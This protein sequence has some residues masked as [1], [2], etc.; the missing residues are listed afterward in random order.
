[1]SE[2]GRRNVRGQRP[3]GASV[4]VTYLARAHLPQAQAYLD[5]EQFEQS[6]FSSVPQTIVNQPPEPWMAALTLPDL[7][8]RWNARLVEYLRYFR[9]NPRGQNLIRG[10]I[11]R[12]GRYEHILAPILR[13]VGV[14]EDLMF[15]AMA[16]SGFNPT[17]RSRVGATG[18]WQFMSGT[19]QVYGL[20]QNYWIDERKDIERA[21]YA[22]AAYLKDLRVR[23]GSWEM[24]LAA[25]NA[26]YALAMKSVARYNTNNFWALC[27]IES[28]LP[29]GTTNYIPKIMAAAIVGRNRAVFGVDDA[30]LKRFVPVKWVSVQIP[31]GIDL[32]AVAKGIGADQDLLHELNAQ[33]IRGRTPPGGYYPVRVPED[34]LGAFQ[35]LSKHWRTQSAAYRSHIVHTGDS[36]ARL[37]RTYRTTSREIRRLNGLSDSAELVAGVT[38]LIPKSTKAGSAEP[39]ERPLAAVPKVELQ[40]GQR[41]VFLVATRAT[42]PRSLSE[43]FNIPW[44]TIVATNDLDPQARLQDGQVL[45]FPVDSGFSADTARVAIYER[46]EVD[47]VIRGSREHIEASLRRR[48]LQRRAYRA[49]RGETLEKIAKKFKLTVGDLARI[50]QFKRNHKPERNELIIVYVPKGKTKG[51]IAAPAP[52]PTTTAPEPTSSA[53][54]TNQHRK[55][56]SKSAGNNSKSRRTPSTA[57]SSRLPGKRG[58]SP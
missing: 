47:Y 57:N 39:I 38:L 29:Y 46:S 49:R 43:A 31:G 41:L 40:P 52:T 10:W 5:L 42:T 44:E 6:R 13:E 12:M 22:A 53:K 20:H 15:V 56:A 28:G 24:A 11:A 2:N 7:P 14:P 8:I 26:G 32:D 54:N 16:E 30:S 51:T 37:A 36:L 33:L 34:K 1:M 9:D 18:M 58:K 3:D 45:Q 27:E 25:F 48:D 4:H 50:N 55:P 21:T 23:F 19:G 17:V 35:Q